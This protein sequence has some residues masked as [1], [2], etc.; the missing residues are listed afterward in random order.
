MRKEKKKNMKASD[1][2]KIN[3]NNKNKNKFKSKNKSNKISPNLFS[4]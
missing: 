4:V 3:K 2:E 1:G